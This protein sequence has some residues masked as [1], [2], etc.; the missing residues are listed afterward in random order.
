MTAGDSG[1]VS[2]VNEGWWGIEVKPQT[3]SGSFYVK[4]QYSGQFVASLQ[5]MTSG[6]TYAV[7]N[8]T[9]NSVADS[10]TQHNFTLNPTS[11]ASDTNNTFSIAYDAAGASGPLNF[12]LISLFPPT[13]NNRPNGMRADLMEALKGLA[14]S[15]LR[16]PGGNNLE[17]ID[18]PYRWKWN[19]TIGPLATRPGRPGVWEYQ[20]TDGL[21][22]IEYLWWCQDLNMEPSMLQP[23]VI[24][25]LTDNLH[26]VLDVW[27]GFY[28]GGPVV[29]EADLGPYV[30][31]VLN[32][33]EFI[34]GDASTEYG[35]LRASLGYPDPIM[36]IKYVE[37]GNEDNLG[38]GQPSYN[39]YRFPAFYN[40][41]KQKYPDMN[42]L[43]SVVDPALPRDA[44]ED[45]HT[46][47]KPDDLVARFNLFDQNTVEDLT[48]VGEYAN[49][50]PNDGGPDRIRFPNW[51]ASVSE[52]VFLIGVS[53]H[54][55]S[56]GRHRA[57]TC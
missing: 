57:L 8:V 25:Y 22:L 53:I 55:L 23:C 56:L 35:G 27:A 12:N 37:V 10:W 4:G 33:L 24:I 15:F 36:Q 2:L 7:T 31:D 18:P 39:D 5:S 21:G 54:S 30:Q 41:I 19:E 42:I 44:I 50:Q 6:D 46:Y 17:G 14:P 1:V 49:S 16:F 26:V 29:S 52:A 9:S 40:A 51:L 13:Y 20:Q 43:A 47:S 34:M 28:L 32:E 38:G 48:L 3:Y 45:Y 11:A